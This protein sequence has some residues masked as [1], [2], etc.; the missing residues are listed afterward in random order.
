MFIAIQSNFCFFAVTILASLAFSA[1]PIE[2]I[3]RYRSLWIY[4][5]GILSGVQFLP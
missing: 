2:K 5:L 1:D 4:S 3:Q